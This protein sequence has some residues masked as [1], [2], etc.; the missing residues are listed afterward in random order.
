ML[1]Y[2]CLQGLR[3]DVSRGI[4]ATLIEYQLYLRN[5][6]AHSIINSNRAGDWAPNGELLAAVVTRTF[7]EECLDSF[8]MIRFCMTNGLI[9]SGLIK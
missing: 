3:A 8:M 7:F 9:T 2:L 5:P 4:L 6:Q 1:S